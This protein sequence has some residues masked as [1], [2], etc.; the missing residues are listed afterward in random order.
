MNLQYLKLSEVQRKIL[1]LLH[2]NL[3]LLKIKKQVIFCDIDHIHITT[4]LRLK[5]I[6]VVLKLNYFGL[7]LSTNGIS[8]L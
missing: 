6:V 5:V 7:E 3:F 4:L 8:I 2:F 1:F